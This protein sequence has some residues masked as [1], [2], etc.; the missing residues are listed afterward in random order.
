MSER[1][2]R[3]SYVYAIENYAG[4]PPFSNSKLAH[5]IYMVSLQ[6]GDKKSPS[7][8]TARR[9]YQQYQYDKRL[10]ISQNQ[11]GLACNY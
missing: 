6:I 10:V 11:R 1:D 3:K 7:V 5:T 8:S 2:R 4:I 9:W